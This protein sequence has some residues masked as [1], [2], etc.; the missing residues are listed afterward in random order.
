VTSGL[1]TQP[2]PR[3]VELRFPLLAFAAV[4]RRTQLVLG[5]AVVVVIF[6]IGVNYFVHHSLE[7]GLVI[8]GGVV[9]VLVLLLQFGARRHYV[10]VESEGLRISGLIRSELVPFQVI[11]QVRVQRLE[12]IF[13]SASR[14]HR[15]DNSLRAF[16]HIPVCV[17][18]LDL[19]RTRV[20]QLGRLLGRGTAVERDLILIV[21]RADELERRLGEQ[22]RHQNSGRAVKHGRG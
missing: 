1:S 14:S 22:A 2:P 8:L 3:V 11:R 10:V 5:Y 18:R 7:L 16:R 13:E 12:V 6:A 19:D 21:A 4:W 9:V 20:A 17:A 15:L